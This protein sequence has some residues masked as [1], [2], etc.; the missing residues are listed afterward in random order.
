MKGNQGIYEDQDK[1]V[2]MVLE[3]TYQPARSL[4]EPT[5]S[6]ATFFFRTATRA[7]S[8]TLNPLYP[9]GDYNSN[10]VVDAADYTVWRDTFGSTEVTFRKKAPEL[11]AGRGDQ[12]DYDYWK[13]KF[14]N[15][16][17][18]CR[19]RLTDPNQV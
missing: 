6:R 11:R 12:E 3:Q 1:M 9:K 16:G 2:N 7:S 4:A 15:V 17:P 10:T 14:G 13:S 8:H 19:R 5:R 18:S